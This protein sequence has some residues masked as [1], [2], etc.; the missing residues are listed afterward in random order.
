MRVII[1]QPEVGLIALVVG[2]HQRPF[3]VGMAQA[4]TVTQLVSRD[5]K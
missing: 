1:G 2:C 4:E 3:D 5:E